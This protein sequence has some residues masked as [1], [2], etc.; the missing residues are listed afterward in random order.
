[1]RGGRIG[2]SQETGFY[3]P[4]PSL[5]RPTTDRQSELTGG[6]KGPCSVRDFVAFYAKVQSDLKQVETMHHDYLQARRRVRD[7]R[8]W[9][10]VLLS[11]Y[12]EDVR[13]DIARRVRG[14]SVITE[15]PLRGEHR[16]LSLVGELALAMFLRL[17]GARESVLCPACGELEFFEDVRHRDICSKPECRRWYR[18]K[19]A[20]ADYAATRTRRTSA[21]RGSGAHRRMEATA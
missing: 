15:F 3:V 16:S 1:M 19:W 11:T 13:L 21:R 5:W 20:R 18:A 9:Q 7:P 12:L 14:P 6:P 10:F 8:A 4:G 17:V 2:E